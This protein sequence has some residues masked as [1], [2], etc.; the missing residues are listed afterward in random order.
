M[1]QL[2]PGVCLSAEQQ[3]LSRAL[4]GEESL[5]QLLR[6]HPREEEGEADSS[7]G[8]EGLKVPLR[9][10]HLVCPGAGLILCPACPLPG[11]AAVVPIQRQQLC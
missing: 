9:S 5:G 7:L 4:R 2:A 8:G 3:G 10:S 1:A 11:P 6:A